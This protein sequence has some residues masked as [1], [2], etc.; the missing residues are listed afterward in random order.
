MDESSIGMVRA[1]KN[2]M[3]GHCR[4]QRVE[5]AEGRLS[6]VEF[7]QS[8]VVCERELWPCRRIN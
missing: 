5:R 2:K 3:L 8:A 7:E 1:L 6:C 4:W